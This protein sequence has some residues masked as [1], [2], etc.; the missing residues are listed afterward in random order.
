MNGSRLA[1][2]IMLVSFPVVGLPYG[3]TNEEA[4][5][6]FAFE[7]VERRAITNSIE[8]TGNVEAVAQV[9][10]GSAVS[11]LLDRVFVNF[12]DTVAAGQPLAELDRGA[13]EA[14]VSGARAALKVATALA[15]VQRSG[16]RRAELGVAAA[17]AERK[18]AEAQA[19]ASQAP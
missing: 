12:N 17:Q 16:L 10:V 5:G 7:A 18:S 19:K 6:G 3:A 8:A 9:D 15:E 1:A 4:G 11:G 13:F 2:T 14:R